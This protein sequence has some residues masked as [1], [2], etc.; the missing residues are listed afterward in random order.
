MKIKEILRYWQEFTAEGR[1]SASRHLLGHSLELSLC[2]QRIDEL[3]QTYDHSGNIATVYAKAKFLGCLKEQ[4]VGLYDV[5]TNPDG[6]AELSK[7]W[8][9][10]TGP[11]MREVELLY[12]DMVQSFVQQA[13]GTMLGVRDLDAE[14][15]AFM[16]SVSTVVEELRIE[17]GACNEDLYR[18]GGVFQPIRKV[19]TQIHMYSRLGECLMDLEQ[20]PD[21]A[22]VCYI[23]DDGSLDGYFGFFLKSNGNLISVNERIDEP[24]PGAN[25]NRRNVRWS[26]SKRY[27]LFPYNQLISFHSPD[28]TGRAQRQEIDAS[29]LDFLALGP[30]AYLPMLLAM[31]ILAKRYE[32]CTFDET[33]LIYTDALLSVNVSSALPNGDSGL[34]IP[35]D[36]IIAQTHRELTVDFPMEALLDGSL[37]CRYDW[38]KSKQHPS[39]MRYCCGNFNN[40]NQMMV[41]MYGAGF[42]F[43]PSALLKADYLELP[44]E[45]MEKRRPTGEFVGTKERMEMLAYYNVRRQLADY[46]RKRIYEE[47]VAYGGVEAVQK[48]WRDALT[49][50]MEK[51]HVLSAKRMLE[52]EGGQ[53]PA[54][55]SPCS[56]YFA[57]AQSPYA[58]GAGVDFTL[59]QNT[60]T[61]YSPHFL[62]PINGAGVSLFFG[63]H[64]ADWTELAAIIGEDIPK[65]VTGWKAFG[66][67][68]SG[69]I[70]L[71]ACDA[72]ASVGT[73]F[74][75]GQSAN[76]L[77]GAPGF[78]N[79]KADVAYFDFTFAVGY[80]KSGMKKLIKRLREEN[81]L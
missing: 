55:P 53:A 40:A 56:I 7:M 11:D 25:S 37:S 80:S 9:I 23:A 1:E 5:I 61:P 31:A 19:S 78:S 16:E 39:K 35:A 75:R 73:P 63:F 69:N 70:I 26:D 10:F 24:Y 81:K 21:G 68:P 3:L 20:S 57:R 54:E 36:S 42:Q 15:A 65:I 2:N 64:P 41:D 13:T 51:I 47:Y 60:G 44:G 14:R 71:D 6:I 77:Y 32:G 27:R 38:K 17:P 79:R 58:V 4:H 59:S 72:V 66:H 30:D 12:I 49:R 74:E 76:E 43:D 33:P 62:C 34:A 48:W 45:G 52:A 29:K 22:Y 46:M 50:N 8:E 67:S 18:R 28:Y